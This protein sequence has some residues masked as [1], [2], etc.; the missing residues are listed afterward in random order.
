MEE[1]LKYKKPATGRKPEPTKLGEV[2]DRML[3]IYKLRGK[4]NES[5]VVAMWEHLAGKAIAKRTTQIYFSNKNLFI[6]LNSPPLAN[7]LFMAKTKFIEML[8][9]EMGSNVVH[10]IIFI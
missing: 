3:D 2:I 9:K 8:N 5:Y 1:I 4:Y 6:Q 10:D 7:E